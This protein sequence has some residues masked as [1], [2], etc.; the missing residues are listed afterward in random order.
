MIYI[1]PGCR[2]ERIINLLAISGEFPYSALK[3]FGD[4]RVYRK[5]I[6]TLSQKQSYCYTE[7]GEVY[8]F[9]LL[10]VSGKGERK[11]VRLY[12][13]AQP[14]L[15]AYKAKNFYLK[16]YYSPHFRGGVRDVERNHR[17]AESVA[18]MMN[19]GIECRPYIV[20]KL[21]ERAFRSG[22][23]EPTFYSSR[24]IKETGKVE[25]NKTSFTRMVG[26]LFTSFGGYIVYNTRNAAMQWRGEGEMKAK[27]GIDLIAERIIG[28]EGINSAILFCESGDVALQTLSEA[29]KSRRKEYRFDGIYDHIHY[30]TLDSAGQRVLRLLLIPRL[31]EEL[32]SLLFD[33][34]ERSFGTGHFDYDAF[35]DEKYIYAFLDG[36]LAGLTRFRE[37]I[38]FHGL[39]G[40]VVC[41]PHDVPLVKGYFQ[42]GVEIKTIDIQT[43]ENEFGIGKEENEI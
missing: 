8:T 11:T 21:D 26:T 18:M 4:E 37:G 38:E 20:P 40:E 36:N 17:I 2:V 39:K 42:D 10:T 25:M 29:G 3:L 41:Y 9:K 33:D 16:T 13:K 43:I 24:E 35:I 14:I 30:I 34:S 22:F 15:E 23:R 6:A 31:K 28:G 1:R 12:K 7:T 19:V 27:V 32:L 5:L